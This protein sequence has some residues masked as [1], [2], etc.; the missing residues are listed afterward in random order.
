ME[1]ERT[2]QDLPAIAIAI[3]ARRAGRV[4]GGEAAERSEGTLDT[5]EHRVPIEGRWP[6]GRASE[7]DLNFTVATI[8]NTDSVEV[9]ESPSLVWPV[10]RARLRR[11][12]V[13]VGL[14]DTD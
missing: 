14:K 7:Q 4:K 6:D 10:G 13:S 11:V 2:L 8:T 5:A 1:A 9:H 3:P 12:S